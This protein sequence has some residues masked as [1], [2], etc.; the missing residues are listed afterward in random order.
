LKLHSRTGTESLLISVRG[1]D[2][3][4]NDPHVTVTSDN[5][6]KFFQ[7]AFKTT[8]SDVATRL[9]AHFLAGIHGMC[10]HSYYI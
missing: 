1:S 8:L 7:L 4:Y 2:S 6:N 10:F 3:A 9:E 5:I